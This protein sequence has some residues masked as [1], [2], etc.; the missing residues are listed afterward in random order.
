[1]DGQALISC[2]PEK[3]IR[4]W[5]AATGKERARFE[6]H[7]GPVNAIALTADGKTLASAGGDKTIRFWDLAGLARPPAAPAPPRKDEF[8]PEVE[9]LWAKV[10]LA[11]DKFEVGEPIP[12]K[13]VVKNFSQQEQTLWHS[14]FW[15][16]HEVI[17]RDGDGKEAPLTGEGKKRR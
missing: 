17:V 2:G 1:P 14:G 12:V 15:P 5:D 8:G 10:T 3:V 11:E 9:G 7:D 4:L 6:G 16:N 13:Y